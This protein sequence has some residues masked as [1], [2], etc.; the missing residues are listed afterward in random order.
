M[1]RFWKSAAALRDDAGWAIALDGKKV[2]TPA[3]RP[4]LVPSEPLALAIADEW[5]RSGETVDP[6]ELPLTGLANA[7]IDQVAPDPGSFAAGIARYAESDL[8]CYRAEAPS[9]LVEL[10][11]ESWDELLSWARRRFDVDFA[12][13]CGIAHVPQPDPTVQRLAHALK[14]LD[15]F[16][17]AAL[18]PLV[19]IGG[20]LVAGL[21][22]L[23][24]AIATGQAWEAVTVDERW[25]LYQWG[26]DAQAQAALELRRRA[27]FDGARF[28]E[29]LNG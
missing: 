9:G 12:T 3:R 21:A 19:T 26:A 25:Q 17:L 11:A 27:F 1:K 6:R 16:R 18:F 4:L 22:V 24:G 29:L 13:T 28:V 5:N 10:Q 7:A 14:S 23:E 20:S 2:R 15:P 8:L